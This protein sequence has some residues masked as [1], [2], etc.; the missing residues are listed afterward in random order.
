M[1]QNIFF[2][3][4]LTV[5]MSLLSNSGVHLI[6]S[7]DDDLGFI[8]MIWLVLLRDYLVKRLHSKTDAIRDDS[9]LKYMV[10]K[11]IVIG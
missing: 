3:D 1:L 10:K 4:L 5:S 7:R 9:L 2:I 6:S 8:L 11:I